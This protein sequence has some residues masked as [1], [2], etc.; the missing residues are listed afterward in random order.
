MSHDSWVKWTL[1][2][3]E[4]DES[5][6]VNDSMALSE[7]DNPIVLSQI[8]SQIANWPRECDFQVTLNEKDLT[9]NKIDLYNVFYYYNDDFWN[10]SDIL[11]VWC[12]IFIHTPVSSPVRSSPRIKPSDWPILRK[13]LLYFDNVVIVDRWVEHKTILETFHSRAY[14]EFVYK[15]VWY[16]M[17][18]LAFIP[19]NFRVNNQFHQNMRKNTLQSSYYSLA[20]GTCGIF[21]HLK[22][23]IGCRL[24]PLYTF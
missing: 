11:W 21:D 13:F 23:T 14:V 4:N 8:N 20:R 16:Q 9:G 24:F 15:W 6:K 7:S 22:P 10:L 18:I 2:S 19:P 5:A 1:Q 17:D 3:D 12:K